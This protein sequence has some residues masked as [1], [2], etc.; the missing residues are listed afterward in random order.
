M[1]GYEV[2]GKFEC[3]PVVWENLNTPWYQQNPQVVMDKY[4]KSM[5]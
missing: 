4:D 3:V 5:N 2:K 1:V